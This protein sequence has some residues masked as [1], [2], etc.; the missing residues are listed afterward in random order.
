MEIGHEE[1]GGSA[2]A[3][4]GECK[5]DVYYIGVA[6]PFPVLGDGFDIVV[7]LVCGYETWSAHGKPVP[8]HMIIDPACL[9]SS[10]RKQYTRPSWLDTAL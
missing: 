9:P 7:C 4:I 8:R 1:E 6:D 10:R 3:G 5:M 2:E